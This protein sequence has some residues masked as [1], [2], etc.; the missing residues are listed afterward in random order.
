[1]SVGLKINSTSVDLRFSLLVSIANFAPVTFLQWSL[2]LC[3]VLVLGLSSTI[4][5]FARTQCIFYWIIFPP[6]QTDIYYNLSKL[7]SDELQW[8][9]SPF[10]VFLHCAYVCWKSV[11]SQVKWYGPTELCNILKMYLT[12][13]MRWI[14]EFQ[15]YF[16][17]VR[18]YFTNK[19]NETCLLVNKYKRY[20]S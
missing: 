19:L 18:F 5:K 11:C 17:R 16:G 10:K 7:W 20:T 2:I 3:T 12:W 13:E 9:T 1:M 14:C 6:V 4:V 8:T 15:I